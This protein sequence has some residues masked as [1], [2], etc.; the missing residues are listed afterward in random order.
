MIKKVVI[1]VFALIGV[2]YALFVLYV[3]FFVNCYTVE[4][5][6]IVSPDGKYEVRYD[7]EICDNY[8]T[9]INIW[10]GERNSKT[11]QLIFSS[12]ATS[13][14]EIH[15]AWKNV[16]NLHVSYPETLKPTTLNS[17]VDDVYIDFFKSSSEITP[18]L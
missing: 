17:E 8:P 14:E 2:I 11:K 13:T 18:S 16:L 1:V 15:L 3:N 12:L 10:L 4:K 5:G 6:L 9:E 7:Q